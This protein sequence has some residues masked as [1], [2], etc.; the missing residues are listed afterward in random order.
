MLSK[1]K[2]TVT[3]PRGNPDLNLIDKYRDQTR[4]Y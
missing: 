1:P 2:N 3:L 4:R